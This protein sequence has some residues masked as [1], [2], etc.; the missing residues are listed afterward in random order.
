MKKKNQYE[1]N[2][3]TDSP[4]ENSRRNFLGKLGKAGVAVA[5]IGAGVPFLDNKTGVLAQ[6]RAN[7]N[8]FYHQRA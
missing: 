2:K 6:S 1:T 5:A 8:S 3:M 4:I 7:G